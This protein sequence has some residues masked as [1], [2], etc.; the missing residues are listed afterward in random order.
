MAD[1]P[2]TGSSE[3]EAPICEHRGHW[4][5]RCGR[6]W[7]WHLSPGRVAACLIAAMGFSHVAWSQPPPSGRDLLVAAE[8]GDVATLKRLIAAGASLHPVDSAKRTPLLIAVEAGQIEAA[9][10]LMEAGASVNAQAANLDTPW[11]LAGAL[12]RTEMLRHMIPRRPD[13]AVR[14]RFGGTALIPACE[15]GHVETVG[16]LLTTEIDVNHVNNL[17]WTCLLEIVILGDGGPRHIEITKL[18]LAAGANPNLADK[19]GVSPLMHARRKAQ[20]EVARLI[21]AAGGR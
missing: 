13:F 4:H 5:A 18:V 12:G 8:R 17:G 15:R 7:S 10:L 3:M 6:Q 1:D 9:V 2:G 21:A 14:N 19:D 20:H 11:L 16:L